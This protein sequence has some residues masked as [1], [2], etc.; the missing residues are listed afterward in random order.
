MAIAHIRTFAC[1]ALVFATFAGRVIDEGNSRALDGVHVRAD[2]PT[3]V[4]TTTD[5]A[6]RFTINNMKPGAYTVTAQSETV[7][8]QEFHVTLAGNRTTV[9][10]L[11]V[12][13]TTFDAHCGPP[14]RGLP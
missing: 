6:G 2:G 12:C 7:P 8:L 10:E 13:S 5:K 1:L 11:K 3:S 4:D 9:I 14:P